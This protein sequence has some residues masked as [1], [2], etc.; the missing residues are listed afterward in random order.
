SVAVSPRVRS[1]LAEVDQRAHDLLLL[2][3]LL[4]RLERESFEAPLLRRLRAAMEAEGTLASARIRRLARLL[5]LLDQRRNQVFAPIA[6]LWHWTTLLAVRIDAWRG[7]AGPEVARWIRAVGEVEA[8][9][10][11]GA[12]AEENPDDPFP[13]L[14]PGPAL[15]DAESIGH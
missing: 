5:H 7:A 9:C 14:V 15:F 1:V 13:D 8:L 3:E 12:Y 6:A 11:L 10:A 2:S 4:A